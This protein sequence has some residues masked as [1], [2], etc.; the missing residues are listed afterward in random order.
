MSEFY[1]VLEHN[2]DFVL[3][4]KAPGIAFHG[5]DIHEGADREGLLSRLKSDLNL[6]AL[7][8]VHRLDRVTSGLLVFAKTKAVNRSLS[9]QFEQREI[10]KYYLAISNKKP[11]KKQGKIVGDMARGRRG[12]WKIAPTSENPAITQFFSQALP[13]GG[14]LFLLKP[15]TGKTHQLRVALKSLGAPILGDTLYS[16]DSADR[17]YLHAYALA[18]TLS[19]IR[20]QFVCA[21]TLGTGFLCEGF[22][23]TLTQYGEPWGLSWPK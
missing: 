9:Q 19:G 18:F 14:R 16:G 11:K 13:A 20:H 2:D 3:V 6:E 12:A 10:E 5:D 1:Q 17:T 15:R 23:Q 21:P 4:D 8:P 7:Y 22:S